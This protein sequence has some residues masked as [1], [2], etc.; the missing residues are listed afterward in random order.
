MGTTWWGHGGRVSPAF[1]DV[2]DIICH[3][4]THF[5]LGFVFGEVLKIEV[6]FITFSVKSFSC[7]M[8]HITKLMLK[9]SL[10]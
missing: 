4:P 6:T 5:S 3:A 9:Q 10:V 7:W 2:G 1:P 8:L